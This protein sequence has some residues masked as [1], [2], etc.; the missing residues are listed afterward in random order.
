MKKLNVEALAVESFAT[1]KSGP[2]TPITVQQC[3]GC[4]STC[5]IIGP[6]YSD[7]CY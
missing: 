4:D 2:L 5:G 3:T 1:A 7:Y 6:N